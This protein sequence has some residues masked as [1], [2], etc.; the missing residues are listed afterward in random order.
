MTTEITIE[1]TVGM[2]IEE[3]SIEISKIR[4]IKESIEI[5]IKIY[6]KAG[7]TR[8]IIEIVT[9]TKI[10]IEANI[11]T[12]TEMIVLIV[13]EVGLEKNTAYITLERIMVWLVVIQRLNN[14]MESYNS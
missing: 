11:E 10:V 13:I 2:T 6:M 3:K 7:A 8:I 1:M 9:K 12:S 14:T 4:S 5:I